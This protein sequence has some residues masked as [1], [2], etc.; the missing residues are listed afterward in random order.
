V[1]SRQRGRG[2][3]TLVS[4]STD[5]GC[6]S[7]V[8]FERRKVMNW[9]SK[10]FDTTIEVEVDGKKKLASKREFDKVLNKALAEGKAK[11]L[12][13]V[14]I[15]ELVGKVRVE[16]W[17][18]EPDYEGWQDKSGVLYVVEG[19]ENGKPNP[20][21]MKKEIWQPLAKL[22]KKQTL[23]SEQRLEQLLASFRR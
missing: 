23:E 17:P 15:L 9:F 14:H 6:I 1:T 8:L 7:E 2:H 5:V 22:W 19:Y 20:S 12:C 10:L 11:R 16:Q 18:W 3:G 13:N 21:I 4:H